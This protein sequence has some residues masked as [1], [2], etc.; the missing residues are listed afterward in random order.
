MIYTYKPRSDILDYVFS[1]S[2]N[3]TKPEFLSYEKIEWDEDGK[4][5][6]NSPQEAVDLAV[7]LKLIDLD[8]KTVDMETLL[9]I[10]EYLLQTKE[11]KISLE[12]C[13]VRLYAQLK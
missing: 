12:E 5:I 1:K 3:A 9:C 11:S 2:F 4:H 10:C 6:A 8:I 7:L 13:E